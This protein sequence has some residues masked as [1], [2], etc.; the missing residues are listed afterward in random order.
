MNYISA[1]ICATLLFGGRSSDDSEYEGESGG[2]G[3]GDD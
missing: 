2:D 1:A 3:D